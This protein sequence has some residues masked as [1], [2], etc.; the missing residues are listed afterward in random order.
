MYYT[1][2]NK[3][4]VSPSRQYVALCK[5]VDGNNKFIS[6]QLPADSQLP[7]NAGAAKHWF[8]NHGKDPEGEIM[9][10]GNQQGGVDGTSCGQPYIYDVVLPLEEIAAFML[11]LPAK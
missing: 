10:Y 2:M 7:N 4:A 1:R 3:D 5:K 6:F 8:G 11:T 9:T